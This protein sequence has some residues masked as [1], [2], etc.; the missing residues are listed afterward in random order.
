L[1]HCG[2]QESAI[3]CLEHA[4]EIRRHTFGQHHLLL[5]ELMIK[6]GDLCQEQCRAVESLRW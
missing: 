2:H 3:A 5:G 6:L 1:E 4:V